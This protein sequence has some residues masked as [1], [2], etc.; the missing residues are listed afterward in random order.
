M[1][2]GLPLLCWRTMLVVPELE[3]ELAT[4]FVSA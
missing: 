1:L 3:Q 4:Y 2:C